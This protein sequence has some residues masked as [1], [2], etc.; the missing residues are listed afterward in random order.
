LRV[1]HEYRAQP[2][3]AARELLDPRLR[4]GEIAA[5]VED[6][7]D[8][9]PPG[10]DV[11]DLRLGVGLVDEARVHPDGPRLPLH[12]EEVLHG[13]PQPQTEREP[14]APDAERRAGLAVLVD[15]V[16]PLRDR[17]AEVLDPFFEGPD[18][19]RQPARRHDH[20][21]RRFLLGGELH[22]GVGLLSAPLQAPVI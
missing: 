9:Q 16:G 21:Q 12:G 20:R 7:Q 1:F 13:V 2:L 18:Q 5:L 8:L 17:E 14:P 3:E 10:H 4:L 6:L 22:Q 19:D 11:S 15:K